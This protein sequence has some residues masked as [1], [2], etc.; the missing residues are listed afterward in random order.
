VELAP[1]AAKIEGLWNLLHPY[2][3]RH[4]AGTP[5]FS[6]GATSALADRL[7]DRRDGANPRRKA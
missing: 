7:T 1:E 5:G 2:H 4:Q 3:E 6:M